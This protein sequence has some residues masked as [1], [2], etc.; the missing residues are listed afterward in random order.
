VVNLPREKADTP[1][2]TAIV[3]CCGAQVQSNLH[4]AEISLRHGTWCPKYIKKKEYLKESA[5][6]NLQQNSENA[7]NAEL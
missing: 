5:E 4:L 6:T 1:G 7:H 3:H 2:G